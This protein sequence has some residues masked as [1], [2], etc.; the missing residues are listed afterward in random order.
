MTTVREKSRQSLGLKSSQP[1]D[2]ES[3]AQCVDQAARQQ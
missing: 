3:A 2:W 1:A